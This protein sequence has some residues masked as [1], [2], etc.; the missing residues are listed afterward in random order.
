MTE[1]DR[2]VRNAKAQRTLSNREAMSAQ[3]ELKSIRSR[4]RKMQHD[5]MGN[6][7]A[8]NEA[9]LQTRIDRLNQR[10]RINAR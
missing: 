3:R 8:R 1:L 10:L 2:Y 6:L 5:R 9:E 7:S 4:E